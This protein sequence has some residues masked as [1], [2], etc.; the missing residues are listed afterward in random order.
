MPGP[1]V[2]LGAVVT[3]SHGGP[4]TPLAPSPRVLAGGQPVVTVG[5]PYAVTGCS[6]TPSGVFCASGHWV[7]GA[8]RVLVMGVPVAVQ[9]GSSVCVATGSPFL[10]M[11]VQPRAVAT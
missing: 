3:C 2:H 6:L 8:A 10:P 9:A 7:T 1:I 11:T 4:A 5:T